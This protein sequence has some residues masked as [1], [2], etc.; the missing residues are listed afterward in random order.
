MNLFLWQTSQTSLF[1]LWVWD[2]SY[3]EAGQMTSQIP[4]Q[5]ENPVKSENGPNHVRKPASL[6][7]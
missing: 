4:F 7:W 2:C 5:P 3:L 6:F 1:F